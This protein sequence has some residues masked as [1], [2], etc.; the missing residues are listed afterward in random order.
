MVAHRPNKVA[1][2]Q[3]EPARGPVHDPDFDLKVADRSGQEG[4]GRACQ[5]V[6]KESADVCRPFRLGYQEGEAFREGQTAR[7][8][9]SGFDAP[10]GQRIESAPKVVYA[11]P[12]PG[13][14]A[15]DVVPR[16]GRGGIAGF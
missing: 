13:P 12:Y 9:R 15:L 5:R 11:K 1:I 2:L 7:I 4:V 6:G 3:D 16:F 8:S 10:E 14:C